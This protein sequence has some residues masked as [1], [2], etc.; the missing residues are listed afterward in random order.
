M[1]L[2][3]RWNM[4][5]RELPIN[6]LIRLC[7]GFIS[8]MVS[9]AIFPFIALYL[10]DMFSKGFASVYLSICVIL[11]F[12]VNMFSG[13]IVDLVP[14]KKLLVISSYFESLVL[15]LMGLSIYY[16]NPIIFISVYFIYI[17]ISTFRRPALRAI[18]QDSV[19]IENKDTTYRLDYWLI[20][21]AMA[22]GILIGGLLYE[23]YKVTLFIISTVVSLGV[24]IL[25]HA[26]IQDSN[27]YINKRVHKNF[28]KDMLK[29]YGEVLKDN[30]FVVLT[31]GI[32]I[33][34]TAELTMSNYVAVRLKSDFSTYN[35]LNYNVD[36]IR[37]FTI[38]NFMNTAIVVALTLLIGRLTK[39]IRTKKLFI[40]ALIIYTLGY[41]IIMMSSDF[42]VLVIFISLATIGEVIYAPIYNSKQMELIPEKRRGSYN[43]FSSLSYTG[44]ELFARMTILFATIL[45][46]KT[47][48][49]VFFVFLILGST[50]LTV[51]LFSKKSM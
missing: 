9:S 7:G 28:V 36:G 22:I 12:F 35:I 37:M 6:I 24:A 40:F 23:D 17:N 39:N 26:A 45:E 10:S 47:V 19:T 27:K 14:R 16:E 11:A 4:K 41:S 33:I 2:N 38:M 25:Y 3:K 5:I 44:A 13:H 50:I 49:L 34:F 18:I 1:I 21:L 15:F 32:L 51:T 29:S 48:A 20:N 8:K 31:L 43:A 46:P 42:W 30:K